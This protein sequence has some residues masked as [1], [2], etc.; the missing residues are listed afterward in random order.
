MGNKDL[1]KTQ[2]TDK[3]RVSSASIFYAHNEWGGVYHQYETWIFSNDPAIKSRQ[4]IW[5]TSISESTK[6]K[7]ITE[8]AHRRISKIM[9]LKFS[10]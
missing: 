9:N 6:L 4:F 5:G 2:I 10:K 7:W 8:N 3:I 1:G